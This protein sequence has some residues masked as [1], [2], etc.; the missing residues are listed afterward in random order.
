MN[1]KVYELIILGCGPAGI[2]AAIYAARK[3]MDFIIISKD[4]GG[5]TIYSSEVENYTGYQVITGAEL[6]FKFKEHLDMFDVELHMPEEVKKVSKQDD[7][8]KVETD[9]DIYFSKTAIIAT[10]RIPRSLGVPNEEKFKGRGLTY[11]ATCDAPLFRDKVV[12]VIGGGN[13]ALDAAIQLT[14]YAKKIFLIDIASNLKADPVMVK[15]AF[16]S[17]IVDYIKNSKVVEIIG[18]NFV[19]GIKILNLENKKET[20]LELQGIFVEIGSFASSQFIDIVE[21]TKDGEI[22]V[23][24]ANRTSKEGIF[25][26]GDVTNVFAK[27]IIIACG[28]G[29]KAALS[30]YE[31]LTRI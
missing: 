15:K 9:K 31:Y 13:S 17:G 24:C 4:I 1:S 28:E 7:I 27:Q 19:E 29:A 21:K 23:D 26:A 12:A 3:K 18:S 2:T 6:V 10:G 5:Q 16:D 20:I 8:I 14:K 25:A 22:I 11:C 30:A